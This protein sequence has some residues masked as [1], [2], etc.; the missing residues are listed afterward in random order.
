MSLR[1]GAGEIVMGPVW[2]VTEWRLGTHGREEQDLGR[3]KMRWR[4][5]SGKTTWLSHRC[6]YSCEN[7]STWKPEFLSLP[8]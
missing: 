8:G 5:V 3:C 7:D 1:R 4:G 6:P 2:L